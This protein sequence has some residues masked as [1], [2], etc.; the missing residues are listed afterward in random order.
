MVSLFGKMVTN[1]NRNGSP[2][3]LYHAK[4]LFYDMVYHSG[5]MDDLQSFLEDDMST[6]SGSTTQVE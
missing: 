2:R 3:D 1:W 5:E 4:G 6:T